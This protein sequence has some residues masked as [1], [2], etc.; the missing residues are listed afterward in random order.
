MAGEHP[1]NRSW[2]FYYDGG[3][4][5]RHE[6]NRQQWKAYQKVCTISTVE[7]FWRCGHLLLLP[8]RSHMRRPCKSTQP[9]RLLAFVVAVRIYSQCAAER[10]QC[11]RTMAHHVHVLAAVC[12]VPARRCAV[13]TRAKLD[14]CRRDT[15]RAL[16]AGYSQ[17]LSM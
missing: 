7:D 6:R 14:C 13:A 8:A 2:T 1:L 3:S 4:D 9:T 16:C 17:I 5:G 12:V 15:L 11:A 10:P